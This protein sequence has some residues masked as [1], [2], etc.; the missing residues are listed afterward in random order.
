[1]GAENHGDSRVSLNYR[2]GRLRIVLGI[3]FTAFLTFGL[4]P[5]IPAV[6][7]TDTAPPVLVTSTVSPK[8]FNLSTGPATV[9]V[10]L[11]ITDATSANAP[12]L[13]V[14]HRATG[15]SHGFGSM[16]LISGTTKDGTW[17][18]T[19][20][21][22][23]GSA[24]GQWEVTLFPLRDSLG[25]SGNFQTLTTLSLSGTP[26][27]TAPPVLV[28]STVSPKTFNLST[29]PATV[30]VTLRITDATSANAPTLSV[31]HRA[32]GQ[33]HGF[34]SMTLIS[35]TTKDGT[36]ERTMTIPQGSALG[37]W[38][39]TL[40]PLRDSL[41][42]SGNFQTLTTLNVN[43][44][45]AP[46]TPTIT[47]IAKAGSTLTAGSGIWGPAPVTLSYQWYRAGIAITGATAPTYKLTGTDTGKTLTVKVTGTKPDYITASRT[48]GA[49]ST[50][51]PGTLT[52][53]VPTITGT[54]K[55]GSTLTASSG[56]WGPAPVTLSYQ[57][58][59]AGI[60]ITGATARTYNLT[61]TDTGKTLT[62][63]I[64]GTKIGYTTVSVSS[65]ITGVVTP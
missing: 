4:M 44:A 2:T 51:A 8:T 31:S 62:V 23:Q 64:T 49:T 50:I 55:A 53:A 46:G 18:R 37:Q 42:N 41:G 52:T 24:L 57:W 1:M 5:Q 56:T 17:E 32:T 27:D 30:K 10:T 43:G 65:A 19:M 63:R 9:K 58:Y 20:T 13:S 14:S 47:G 54:A 60:A 21:I 59:R 11:R 12:T 35:G 61:G 6:A 38:E 7:A 16:T 29:G 40:F 33:S 3:V 28:T 34:G 15:Q 45:L 36:W 48:S 26:T 22:P 39:V 25:N